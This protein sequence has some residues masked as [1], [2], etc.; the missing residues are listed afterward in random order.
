M[1]TK[2]LLIEKKEYNYLKKIISASEY[3]SDAESKKSLQRLGE[4]LV[5]AKILTQSE[6]PKN[7][8]RINSTVTISSDKGWNK[9]L[10]IVI[11]KEKNLEQ[12]KISI[13][14]PMGSAL[15]GYSEGDKII[16]D[17]PGG[18]QIFKIVKVIQGEEFNETII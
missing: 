9:T 7:T 5:R 10:K 2:C 12:N 15:I 14:T 1:E 3:S 18:K 11:P 8:I 13:L 4:E 17:L 6:I 16:W